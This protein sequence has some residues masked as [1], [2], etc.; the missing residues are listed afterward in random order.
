MTLRCFVKTDVFGST[1]PPGVRILNYNKD[2]LIGDRLT[3]EFKF[4]ILSIYIDSGEKTVKSRPQVFSPSRLGRDISL[5]NRTD[6]D[7]STMSS[8]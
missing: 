8:L 1:W 3:T 2:L 4:M 7:R 6:T 5:R